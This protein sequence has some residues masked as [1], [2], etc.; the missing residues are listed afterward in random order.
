MLVP[1]PN[2]PRGG[3]RDGAEE[4]VG[5]IPAWTKPQAPPEGSGLHVLRNKAK[6]LLAITLRD[7]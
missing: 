2:F 5:V 1:A 3:H 7:P 6:L 4:L